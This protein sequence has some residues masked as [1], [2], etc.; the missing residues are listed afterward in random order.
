MSTVMGG[1]GGKGMIMINIMKLCGEMSTVIFW[2]A[3]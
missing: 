2:E 1:G 3:G